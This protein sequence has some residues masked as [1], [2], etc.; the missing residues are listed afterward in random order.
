MVRIAMRAPRIGSVVARLLLAMIAAA[1]CRDTTAPSS[2][3]K[4]P[5]GEQTDAFRVGGRPLQPDDDARLREAGVGPLYALADV[6]GDERLT[7]ADALAAARAAQGGTVACALAADV[8]FDGAVT[9]DDLR[10]VRAVAGY[11]QLRLFASSHLPCAAFAR[12]AGRNVGA[13]GSEVPLLLLG[14]LVAGAER[15]TF[16]RV[17]SGPG[18][19]SATDGSGQSFSVAIAVDARAGDEVVV[20]VDTGFERRTGEAGGRAPSKLGRSYVVHIRVTGSGS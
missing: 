4:P 6:D 9:D 15:G 3:S 18:I 2:E 16:V 20:A 8:D 12:V 10:F 17:A 7:A 14:D 5:P 11:N 1:G 19:V 13:P